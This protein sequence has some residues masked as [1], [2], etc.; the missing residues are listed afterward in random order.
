[1][2]ISR[3]EFVQHIALQKASLVVRFCGEGVGYEALVVPFEEETLLLAYPDFLAQS[4]LCASVDQAIRRVMKF[5]F[6]PEVSDLGENR[7]VSA[8]SV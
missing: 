4:G 3:D 6:F 7:V 2:E 8:V 5:Y 1:M